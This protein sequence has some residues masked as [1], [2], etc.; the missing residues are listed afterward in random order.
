MSERVEVEWE[1]DWYPATIL[2]AR[3]AKYKI[4][5][6]GYSTE[7]D[8]WIEAARLRRRPTITPASGKN[9][10]LN[11]RPALISY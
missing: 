6:L 3:G 5:Y 7:W 11:F 10:S 9:V 1:G 4:H 8:E 2:E